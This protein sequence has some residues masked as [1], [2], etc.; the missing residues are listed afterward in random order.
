ML[1]LANPISGRGRGRRRAAALARV[2][3]HAGCA[4]EVALS[5][6]RADLVR[7]AGRATAADFDAVAVIGGD[8]TLRTVL[9]GLPEAHPPL[10]LVACG[11]ANSLARELRLPRAPRA[12]VRMIVARRG[13]RLATGVVRIDGGA[14]E[15]FACF[16]GAGLDAAMVAELERRRRGALP[17]RLG[18]LRPVLRIA[19]RLPRTRLAARVGGSAATRGDLGEVLATR[20]RNYG[21]AFRLPAAVDPRADAL[22]ALTFAQRT[23]AAWLRVALAGWLRGLDPARGHCT[24]EAARTLTVVAPEPVPVQADGDLVGRGRHIEIE[25]ADQR[26]ALLVPGQLPGAAPL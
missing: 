11:T 19:R 24:C 7:L 15:R 2:L 5:E 14:A 22:F 20:I 6:S 16:A 23:R 4:A 10:A 26:L 3:S 13:L 18:W 8:G 17:G 9:A 1:V 12:V 25:L 21:S